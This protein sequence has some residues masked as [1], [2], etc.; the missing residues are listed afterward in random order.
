MYSQNNE[1][2]IILPYFDALKI[3]KGKFLDIGAYDGKTFSNTYALALKGWCGVELEP[4]PTLFPALK[5]NLKD[6]D[7][8][9]INKAIGLKD[10]WGVEFYDCADA[11]S[12]F[13]ENHMKLWSTKI[14]YQK[15]KVDI[16]SVNTLFKDEVDHDFINLDVE[17]L[18]WEIYKELPFDRLTNLKMI[19]VEHNNKID[20]M[21]ALIKPFGF[22]I[23]LINGE[24]VIFSK[25]I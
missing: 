4:S 3:K 19:C 8:Q 14:D 13:D 18:N 20:E 5:E 9:L 10:A 12:T 1:E 6:F 24:N 25:P 21:Y 7:I 15:T 16:I 22:E 17:G 2:E 11:V 23:S